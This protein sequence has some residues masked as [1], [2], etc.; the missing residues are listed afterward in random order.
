MPK[1]SQEKLTLYFTS[2]GSLYPLSVESVK[3]YNSLRYHAD[4]IFPEHLIKD[5][6]P[7]ESEDILAYRQKTYQ[8]ITKL[9]VSKVIT[10]FGKIRRSKDWNINFPN[11]EVSGKISS[12]ETLEKYC[13]EN[14]P[15]YGSVTNWAFGILLRQNLLDANA[16]IAVVPTGPIVANE[17]IKPVPIVFN[18]D[19]VIEFNEQERYCILRSKRKVTYML[20]KDVFQLGD[21]FYYIDDKE[22]IVYEQ[23]Q[24]GWA[25]TFQ[26][27]N[28]TGQMTAWKVKAESFQ[29]Y[30]NMSLN[31]SRI[32]AMVPFLDEAACDYS[33]YKGS[34][35]QHL[36]PL[37]WYYQDKE[38][39]SCKGSGTK[40]T[41]EGSVTCTTCGGGGKIKFSPF[42][43]IEVSAPDLGKSAFPFNA[44]AGYVTRDVA[45]LE[46]QDKGVD[47]SMFKS[48]SAVNMQFLDQTPLSIS[49]DA[50]NVDREELNNSVYNVA[51]DLVYSVEKSI[52]FI[53]EWRYGY[54]VPDA[55]TRKA[56]LPDIAVPE[57][58]DL[59]P[60]DY[61][62]AEVVAA[63]TGKVSP[64]LIGTLEQQLAAKKFY[65]EPDLATNIKLCFDLDPL[66]GMSTDEKMTMLG[67]N[68]ITQEDVVLSNYL[69]SFV[70][71]ALREHD[72][73]ATMEYEKQMEVLTG[74]VDEKMKSIDKAAK[75]IEDERQKALDEV[76][77]ANGNKGPADP[78][79][80][81]PA[82][83]KEG[84]PAA[85]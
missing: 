30:D 78:N 58:F 29:Q 41:T 65:N 71:R 6:R 38:C 74:Y 46:L 34:K 26:V 21:I 70:K 49:G 66:L 11:D 84:V 81:K 42:A 52:F 22:V 72:D 73:F 37:F 45:I 9:P 4:G 44:P 10:S 53:N 16:V 3:L 8:P 27:P 77:A 33:D 19:Q 56:M 55:K 67:N 14:L 50:K 12:E 7:S 36:Y 64:L 13:T 32:D 76:A 62:M 24:G 23:K 43:H 79:A 47:K 35:I 63:R 25:I 5:R 61:L 80:A 57:N 48:L 2:A 31:R 54:L 28:I 51:E 40:P 60:A 17:Y 82:D 68:S 15:G 1:I 75:M 18:S 39:N 69:P 59:L 83:K 20:D 85:A